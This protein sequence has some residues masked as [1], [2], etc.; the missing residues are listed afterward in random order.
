VYHGTSPVLLK[1]LAE[2]GLYDIVIYGHTHQAVIEKRG[3]TLVVN[4]GELCGCL[5]GR[6][7]YAL[8]NVEKLEVD[9]I[10]LT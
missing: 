5:T 8:I 2:S 10:Y 3:R 7:S 1:A 6:S 9:L 4:P